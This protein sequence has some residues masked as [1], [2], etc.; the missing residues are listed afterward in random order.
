MNSA[1]THSAYIL[2]VANK[3]RVVLLFIRR[4]FSCLTKD[5]FVPLYNS[6]VRPH[7][8]YA[9]QANFPHLKRDIN[10]LERI[11]SATTRLVKGLRGQTYEETQS[12]ERRRLGYLTTIKT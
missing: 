1:F 7:L 4:S 8:K 10:H 11:P 6:L 2:A 3:A 5:I 9:I 12:L